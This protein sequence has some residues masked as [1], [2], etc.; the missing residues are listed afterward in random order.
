M[1]C[2][3]ASER[4]VDWVCKYS[5]RSSD[6]NDFCSQEYFEISQ[7]ERFYLF[8]LTNVRRCCFSHSRGSWQ[9]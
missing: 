3:Q 6:E 4:Y 1:L 2:L 7:V 9:R 5:R 8:N